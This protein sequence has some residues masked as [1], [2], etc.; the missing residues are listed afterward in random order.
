MERTDFDPTLYSAPLAV[1]DFQS[2][3]PSIFIA[4]NLCYSTLLRSGE[5]G[6]LHEG[7]DY[8]ACPISDHLPVGHR[9]VT[10]EVRGGLLPTLMQRLLSER[11]QCQ[12]DKRQADQKGDS[13]LA[14]VLDSRQKALKLTANAMY[15]FCG[16]GVSPFQCMPLAETCLRFGQ[17]I[18]T[19]VMSLLQKTFSVRVV[20]G[21][22]DSLFVEL[23]AS[24]IDEA[25]AVAARM[26]D[27][28]N[29][30]LPSCIRL[31]LER[32]LSPA[33]LFQINRY[34]GVER[35][36]MSCQQLLIK[37]LESQ[38]RSSAPLIRQWQRWAL[39]QLLVESVE[40]Q[41]IVDETVRFV[42]RMFEG[43]VFSMEQFILTAALWRVEQEDIN[44][45]PAQPM[46]KLLASANTP[47]AIVAI[48]RCKRDGQRFVTG[49]RLSFVYVATAGLGAS[50]LE[51][52]ECPVYALA[53][54]LPLRYD[55][56]LHKFKPVIERTLA[57]FLCAT[58]L[59]SAMASIAN[60]KR[61]SRMPNNRA[62]CWASFV[63]TRKCLCCAANC[64][65][66]GSVVFQRR[67]AV[68]VDRGLCGACNTAEVRRD[69]C[70][71]ELEA[72]RSAELRLHQ[73][74]R[75]TGALT[76]GL[77]WRPRSEQHAFAEAH[78]LERYNE[79][80]GKLEILGAAV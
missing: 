4:Y 29:A 35:V 25:N 43:N 9:F 78:A 38:S 45:W 16:A 2:L 24:S 12:L 67:L 21:Q 31:V 28:A 62:Q 1:L 68:D 14:M 51:E 7:R 65:H 26:V 41:R 39:Q 30:S 19:A 79:I 11:R 75:F 77:F 72:L 20:Y 59:R 55:V 47:A 66:A 53:N 34:S 10:R 32:I 60:I 22:T 8:V 54:S 52:A 23:N 80:L 3:Y 6:H 37:G 71:A 63:P 40:P 57:P 58:S 64:G 61:V 76:G 49:E 56:Y 69:L 42:E 13:R 48:K 70:L 18:S 44:Q 50:Q 27:A 33:C 15:G 73:L 36:S 46:S 74:R 17:A 5:D